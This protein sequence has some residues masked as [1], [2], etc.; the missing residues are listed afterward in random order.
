MDNESF[1]RKETMAEKP[2][3]SFLNFYTEIKNVLLTSRNQ[4]YHAVNFSMVQAYWNVGRIIAEHEQAGNFRAEYG[5]G[6]LQRLSEELT[7]E[8][9]KGFDVRNLQQMKKFYTLFPN[10]NAVRSQ[11]TW[12]HYRALLRVEDDTAR[13]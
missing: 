11:L 1:A 9:G 10:T 8:F 7:R 5:K 3:E 6:V 2:Q 12:T 13:N 4:A